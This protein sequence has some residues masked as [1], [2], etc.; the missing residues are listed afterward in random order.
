VI[1][2]AGWVD[3]DPDER[4]RFLEE[5]REKILQTREEPGCITYTLSADAV[6]PGRVRFFE[7]WEDQAAIDARQR[8]KVPTQPTWVKAIRR[9]VV[10]YEVTSIVNVT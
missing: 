9:E 4:G 8:N 1:I 2:L 10:S 7:C 5:R 6:D 3:V